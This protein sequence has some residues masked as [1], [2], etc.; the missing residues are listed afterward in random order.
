[1][2]KDEHA[3]VEEIAED[4][5]QPTAALAEEQVDE[6]EDADDTSEDYEEEVF[7]DIDPAAEEESPEDEEEQLSE[8]ET[9]ALI[10]ALIFANGNLVSLSRLK[11]VSGLKSS[12]ITDAIETIEMKFE[13]EESGIE[14][15]TVGSKYQFRTK[16]LYSTYIRQLNASKPRKLSRAALETLAIIAYR[17]PIVKSDVEKIRGVDASPTLKTL[18]DKRLIKIVGHQA[19]VGQPALY[20][21]TDEFLNIFGMQ[22][23]KELPSLRDV[24]DFENEPGEPGQEEGQEEVSESEQAEA[25]NEDELSEQEEDKSEVANS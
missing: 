24:K 20:G 23:L 16:G 18:L 1:M 7:G 19:S 17:Q 10:E 9:V 15:V 22:S 14:L 3:A 13:H 4:Q 5:E 12:Q 11:E 2:S 8:A 6:S 21:T 25:S